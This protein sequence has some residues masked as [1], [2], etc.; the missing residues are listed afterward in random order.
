M[1]NLILMALCF[2]AG[3]V[4]RRTGRLPGSAPSVL[5]SYVIHVALPAMA[6]LHIHGLE[7]SPE[8]LYPVGA[9][10]ILFGVGYLLFRQAGRIAN[11]SSGTLGALF[12]TGALGNTSFVGLP[13]IEA[14]YGAEL[15]GVGILIDQL[16][17]FLILSTAGIALAASCSSAKVTASGMIRKVLVFPTFVAMIIAF[18]MMPLPFPAWAEEVLGRIGDTLA[19]LALLSVGFQLRLDQIRNNIGPLAVGLFY[20]LL[21][22]PA[23]VALL[24]I[25]ILGARGPVIQVTIF[26]TAMAPMITGSIVAAEH[27]LD[28]SLSSLMVGVGIPLS[29]LTLPLWWWILAPV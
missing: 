29:F 22:G 21:L 26:E 4:L 27:N 23:I 20:K 9:A 14:F 10:W 15:L 28:P 2:A 3:I 17:S 5:N 7:F 24:F 16:G 6:L 11:Y 8:L 12:L 13:M 19:P 25:V 18:A 1:G